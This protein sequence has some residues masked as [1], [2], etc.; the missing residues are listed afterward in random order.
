MTEIDFCFNVA[1]KLRLVSRYALKSLRQG[2]RLFI[3]TPDERTAG[4]VRRVLW[5]FEQT[6][7]IPHCG[8]SDTLATETPV[9]VDH[10][11][12]PLIHDDVLL[13]LSHGHP[14]FFSR[15]KRLIEIV[16]NEDEDKA[17][18]RERFRFY[19]DRGYEIRRH[20]MAGKA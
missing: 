16:G 5:S 10:V 19:R 12:E 9:I 11:A 6:S 13:N 7:F 20:D 15:F 2:S 8:C 17:V 18:A 1:D 14:P 3:F 4:E